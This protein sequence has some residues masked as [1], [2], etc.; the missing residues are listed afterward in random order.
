MVGEMVVQYMK[1]KALLSLVDAC[2]HSAILDYVIPGLTSSLLDIKPRVFEYTGDG[3]FPLEVGDPGYITPHSH[4]YAFY[5][6]VLSGHVMNSVYTEADD[7]EIFA[8]QTLNYGGKPGV[9][10][11]DREQSFRKFSPLHQNYF[12]GMFYYMAPNE[13]HTIRFRPGTK[14]LMLEGPSVSLSTKV[15]FPVVGGKVVNTM[16]RDMRAFFRS[17]D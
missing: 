13:I 14:V 12:E 16:D 8:V 17:E 2:K 9:Y 4:R 15:L 10:T 7:G 5:A 11:L 6:I 1:T 3:H